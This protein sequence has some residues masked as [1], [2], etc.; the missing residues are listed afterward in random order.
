MS[1]ISLLINLCHCSCTEDDGD[2]G[3][4]FEYLSGQVNWI[5]C[6]LNCYTVCRINSRISDPYNKIVSRTTQLARLQVSIYNYEF[7]YCV[8]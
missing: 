3:E 6:L 1:S 2:Q 7:V 5:R 8:Y 4:F